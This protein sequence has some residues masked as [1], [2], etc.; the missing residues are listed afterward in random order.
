MTFWKNVLEFFSMSS[1]AERGGITPIRI[2]ELDR[3]LTE[4][5]Q[6]GVIV[7]SR[8]EEY[9]T[10][11]WLSELTKAY[12]AARADELRFNLV[13]AF[14]LAVFGS[15]RIKPSSYHGKL[16]RNFVQ[17]VIET[18]YQDDIGRLIPLRIVTGG[19]PGLME[20]ANYGAHR[21]IERNRTNG[22]PKIVVV[23]K[24]ISILGTPTNKVRNR[25]VKQD[26]DDHIE[27]STRKQRF[28]DLSLGAFLAAGGWGTLYEFMMGIQNK[29]TG[30]IEDD[31]LIVAHKFWQGPM[32]LFYENM[33]HTRVRGKQI[34]LI[35][36]RDLKLVQFVSRTEEAVEIFTPAIKRWWR[37]V[38]SL[39]QWID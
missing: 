10:A 3:I 23:N 25:Y 16:V 27:F 15:S 11:R 39:V 34:S 6:T 1:S 2:Q 30:H 29:Q 9:Q 21:A 26:N 12:H 20:A 24:G 4:R 7:R 28:L 14:G 38:G 22:E 36:E 32:E 19:G 8:I 17:Q 33:Y 31:Y 18:N 5:D 35:T 13:S 37:E